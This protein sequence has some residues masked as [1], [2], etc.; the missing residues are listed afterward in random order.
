MRSA[1]LLPLCS[2]AIA[3]KNLLA[4]VYLFCEIKTSF[5]TQL[6][7]TLNQGDIFVFFRQILNYVEVAL[8]YFSSL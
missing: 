6:S 2:A 1:R 5:Y 3:D 8:N 4:I 7:R